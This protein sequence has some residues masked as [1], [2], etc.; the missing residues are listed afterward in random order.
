M[1]KTKIRKILVIS[2]SNIGDVVLT[3]PVLDIL[4]RDFPKAQISVVVGPKAKGLLY[5]N[6]NFHHIYIF[7]KHQPWLSSA[8][9]I[10]KLLKT[11]Y[12]L[13]VDLRNTMIP[14]FIAPRYMTPLW[15]RRV[16]RCLH[17]RD[18][19]LN[20]LKSIYP[21]RN[22]SNTRYSLFITEKDSSYIKNLL[23][24]E[25]KDSDNR[26]II[27]SPGAADKSK[28][29]GYNRFAELCDKIINIYNIKVVLIGDAGED[30]NIVVKILKEMKAPAMD[31]AGKTSLIQLAEVIKNALLVITNDSAPMHLASYLN[32]PVLAIFGPTSPERYGPWSNNSS[33]I[34]NNISCEKCKYPKSGLLHSCM[35]AIS[36]NSVFNMFKITADGVDFIN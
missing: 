12:D 7:N 24:N 15:R 18:E 5:S 8:R 13:V 21:Y 36:V 14:L 11:R 34:R 2:L 17:V 27:V 10:L 16:G 20:R 28:R 26:Y 1:D 32:V 25:F 6:P 22:I 4:K 9:W 31:I 19:H 30:K 33:F 23:N 35:D 29:W 3:F